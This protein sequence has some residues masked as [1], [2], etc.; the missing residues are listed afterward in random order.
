MTSQP[1]PPRRATAQQ[2]ALEHIRDLISRGFLA[3]DARIRQEQLAADLGSSV[4]PVREALKTLE[5]EGQV[6]Y[7]P[8]RGYQVRRLG[9]AELVETYRLRELL[10]D[11]AVRL[12]VP[13]MDESSFEVLENAMAVMESASGQADLVTMTESNRLFHFTIFAAADMPRMTDFIRQLWQ[14]TDAYRYRYYADGSHRTRVN[15]EHRQIVDALR[16]RDTERVVALVGAHREA[17]VISLRSM[18]A[19][20]D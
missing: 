7:E 8:H 20:K 2:I 10:E 18:L 17:A 12:A 11:E 13:R 4:I 6:V 3:P 5:A 19:A 15:D 9:L 1:Q 16:E 14:S